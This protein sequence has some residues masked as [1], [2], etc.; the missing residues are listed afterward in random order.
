MKE[1]DKNLKSS[2][3]TSSGLLIIL[4][5]VRTQALSTIEVD[6]GSEGLLIKRFLVR[7]NSLEVAKSIQKLEIT[8]TSFYIK[9]LM[10]LKVVQTMAEDKKVD[11]GDDT[12]E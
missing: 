3:T 9:D 1:F 10:L 12:E 8:V 2:F 6:E 4:K 11:H 7:V 5:V